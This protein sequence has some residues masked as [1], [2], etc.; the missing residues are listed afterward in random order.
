[1]TNHPRW[2]AILLIVSL[3]ALSATA[4]AQTG[5][6][7]CSSDRGNYRYCRV[8]TQNQVRL[9]RVLPGAKCVSGRSWGYDYRGIW[10][11]RGC[12]AQFEYGRRG[13]GGGNN[14]GAAILGG[15][16]GGLIAGAT[17]NSNSDDRAELRRQYYRDGYRHGQRDWDNDRPPYYRDY[18]DR[19]PIEFEGDFAAGYDDGYN[20]APSRY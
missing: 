20:N 6:L 10:V 5:T 7:T 16:L 17:T 15:I 12:R 8:D 3:I 19:Y 13:G 1:M 9:V 11:D 14:T 2:T 18:R 4:T